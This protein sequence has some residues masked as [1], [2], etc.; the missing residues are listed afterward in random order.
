[1]AQNDNNDMRKMQQEAI[2]R[3]QEMQ[4][5]ARSLSSSSAKPAA[6]DSDSP[7]SNFSE[8][9]AEQKHV[10]PLSALNSQNGNLPSIFEN[11]MQDSERTLILVLILLLVS[12]KADSELIFALMY[13][14][15]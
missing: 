8:E 9:Q 5:R 2:R 4:S 3:V 7:P 6:K 10:Q 15:I 12:E 14:I 13:L 11:L 1:M